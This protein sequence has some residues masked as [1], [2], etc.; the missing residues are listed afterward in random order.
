MRHLF[1][2]QFDRLPPSTNRLYAR[3]QQGVYK[4]KEVREWQDY[5]LWTLRSIATQGHVCLTLP[6]SPWMAVTITAGLPTTA[7]KRRDIDNL[8]KVVLDTLVNE[9]LQSDDRY[10][11]QLLVSKRPLE[12]GEAAFLAV[13]VALD[14]EE[15][16]NGDARTGAKPATKKVSRSGRRE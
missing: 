3:S 7:F 6:S 9:F 1:T 14:S 4:L 8:L 15:P 5:A 16:L 10:V 11:T 12:T 2:A 13:S